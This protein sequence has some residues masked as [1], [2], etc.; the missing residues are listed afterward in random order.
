MEKTT[1]P[2]RLFASSTHCSKKLDK[3]SPDSSLHCRFSIIDVMTQV[4]QVFKHYCAQSINLLELFINTQVITLDW[5][6][7][8]LMQFLCITI[9]KQKHVLQHVNLMIFVYWTWIQ[10]IPIKICQTTYHAFVMLFAH[11]S[12]KLFID[13]YLRVIVKAHYFNQYYL[14]IITTILKHTQWYHYN[15]T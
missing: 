13:L 4:S 12:K 11:P 9:F 7:S 3:I 8:D 6:Y 2:H 1:A 5:S 15:K 14:V 10:V